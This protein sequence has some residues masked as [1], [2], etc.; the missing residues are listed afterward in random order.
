VAR[1][2]RYDV[3][4]EE[5]ARAEYGVVLTADRRVDVT[6]TAARRSATRNERGPASDFD[7]GYTPPE[8]QEAAE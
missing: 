7:F 2:V 8:R 1:D 3:L 6:A 5:K 4:S